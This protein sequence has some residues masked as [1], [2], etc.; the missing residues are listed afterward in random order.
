MNKPTTNYSHTTPEQLAELIAAGRVRHDRRVMWHGYVS[1]RKPA[2]IVLD[3]KSRKGEGFVL[4][5]PNWK[6]TMFCYADYYL[7]E[8]N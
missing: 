5:T 4:L 1:R 2:G 6:S 8:G 7:R 3:Y